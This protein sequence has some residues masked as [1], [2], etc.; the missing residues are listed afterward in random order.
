MGLFRSHL[1]GESIYNRA[2][3]IL[4]DIARLR[5]T[6]DG[7]TSKGWPDSSNKRLRHTLLGGV[8]LGFDDSGTFLRLGLKEGG[9]PI[10][11]TCHYLPFRRIPR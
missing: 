9:M 2:G 6:S 4:I 5:N 3:I 8:G 7:L 10:Y 1:T 11:D